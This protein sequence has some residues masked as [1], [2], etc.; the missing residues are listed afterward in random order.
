MKLT[1][2]L[3]K[4]A[5]F[6]ILAG[7][8]AFFAWNSPFFLTT[9]NLITITRQVAVIGICAVGMTFV[10]LTGGI[11]LSVSSILGVSAALA[12]WLMAS[13]VHPVLATLASLAAGVV[14]GL[15]NGFFINQIG[16]PPL[17]TTL[18]TMTALRGVVMLIT[19]GR[20][21]AVRV[22]E[23]RFIGQGSI[24]PIP[25]PVII[26]IVMFALGYVILEMT[27]FGRYVYG[28]GDNQEATRLSGVNVKK[29]KYAV[30]A[31][32]GLLAALAG[33]V[34]LS[35]LMSVQAI[36]GQGLELEII[37]AVVL[38]GVAITGGEGKIS[39]VIVGVLIMGVLE[40]GM[41]HMNIDPFYQWIVRGGVLLLAVSYSKFM[42]SRRNKA[43]TSQGAVAK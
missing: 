13:G 34:A 24:G 1:N 14:F 35:R 11:D 8:I 36:T 19:E 4:Y 21:I 22:S 26:M 6:I 23:Y 12:A 3:S 43:L 15:L 27:K 16:L 33:I 30:Y 38:G 20:S 29:V 17:I 25:V 28:V 32:S 18:G 7:L 37:T 41:I 5:L 10:I 2:F 39:L 31:L 42:Q 9:T 40:N